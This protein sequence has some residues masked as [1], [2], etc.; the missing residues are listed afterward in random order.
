MRAVRSTLC[1]KGE[2]FL[3]RP[4]EVT[5]YR[6]DTQKPWEYLWIGF[7]GRLAELFHACPAVIR[8][9]RRLMEG[10]LDAFQ[11]T[12][13]REEFLAGKLFLLLASLLEGDRPVDRAKEAKNYLDQ[14]YMHAVRLEELA[15]SLG[16]DRRY[17][18]R[19]FKRGNGVT[20]QQYLTQ[21]RMEEA[22]RLLGQNYPVAAVGRMVGYEDAFHFSKAF[23]QY[24]GVCPRDWKRGKAETGACIRVFRWRCHQ[25]MLRLS[26]RPG[27]AAGSRTRYAENVPA[28]RLFPF[29]PL[30]CASTPA[31]S[32]AKIHPRR[33]PFRCAQ[34]SA[35]WFSRGQGINLRPYSRMAKMLTQSAAESSR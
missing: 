2:A 11:L 7:T 33:H 4:D 6:A 27:Y 20:M 17:L 26:L 3:I 28:R 19:L 22:A 35:R 16:L 32:K 25:R 23:R 5:T 12:G 1:G 21:R 13:M 15:R 10:M 8:P 31:A 24:Y 14:N 29:L 34:F 30:V 9:E 18:S